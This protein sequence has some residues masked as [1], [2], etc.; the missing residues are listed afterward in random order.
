[1]CTPGEDG[2]G[3]GLW[4]WSRWS[5]RFLY[6]DRGRHFLKHVHGVGVVRRGNLGNLFFHS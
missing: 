2:K 3:R 5:G 6:M 4:L 1:M